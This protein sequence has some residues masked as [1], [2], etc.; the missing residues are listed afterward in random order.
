MSG[1]GAPASARAGWR[2]T[3]TILLYVMYLIG[4]WGIN[5]IGAVLLPL[6]TELDVA[7]A[8]VA[9]YPTLYSSG[10]VAVG[11]A[12]GSLVRRIGSH[13]SLVLAM[14][15]TL[16]GIGLMAVPSQVVIGLGAFVFGVG[17][18][19][20]TLVMPV[21]AGALHG[22]RA[23]RVMTEANGVGSAGAIVAPLVVAAALALSLGWRVGYVVPIAV[24]AAAVL[25]AL[26]RPS[27]HSPTPREALPADAEAR[28]P[29][30]ALLGR[31]ADIPLCVGAEFS[32]VF[33]AAAA[34]SEWH[35]L[36]AS[37]AAISVAVFLSGLALGRFAGSP[38]M[39]RH[40]PR[41]IVLA[42]AGVALVGFALFWSLPVVWG[43]AA[44]LFIAGMG[45]ALLFPASLTRLIRIDPSDRE[46]ASQ[47]S[48]L[49][50]GAAVA[51]APLV[52]AVVADWVGIRWAYLMVPA[53]LVVLV[54]KNLRPGRGDHE[55]A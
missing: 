49:G 16:V 35:A 18:A 8:D 17:G 34:W 9:L 7:R 5:G 23:G 2:G 30:R 48:V 3:E 40:P 32:L 24:G 52:L 10:L 43:S 27:S 36:S 39:D 11:L 26:A 21:R 50:L 13:R 6:Q 15:L 31:W 47:L 45:I 20:V 54:A 29:L 1:T 25:V 53:F 4:S 41:H 28:L 14:V 55:P 37:G 44:G 12:G 19:F 38:L 42:G 33:W 51:L 46:R 22:A